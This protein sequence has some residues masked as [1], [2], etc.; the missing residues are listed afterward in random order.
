M[1]YSLFNFIKTAKDGIIIYL[2]RKSILRR[3]RGAVIGVLGL[4]AVALGSNPVLTPGQDLFPDVPDSTLTLPRFVNSQWVASC[5]LG[6]L[7]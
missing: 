4:H 2:I 5:Q 1:F 6:F 7:L 3:R